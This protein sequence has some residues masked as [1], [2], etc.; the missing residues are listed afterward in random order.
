MLSIKITLGEYIL[1]EM[2]KANVFCFCSQYVYYFTQSCSDVY[3]LRT[4]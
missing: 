1:S 4:I 2:K 3:D